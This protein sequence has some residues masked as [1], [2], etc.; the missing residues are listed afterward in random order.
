MTLRHVVSIVEAGLGSD[1]CT[2]AN[3]HDPGGDLSA[4]L[5]EFQELILVRVLASA[6]AYNSEDIIS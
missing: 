5:D 2:G 6:D 3:R 1:S 4:L